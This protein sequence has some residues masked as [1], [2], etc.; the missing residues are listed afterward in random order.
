MVELAQ[1]RR[2]ELLEESELEEAAG[3][4]APAGDMARDF[5]EPAPEL[6]RLQSALGNGAVARAFTP[7]PPPPA[8]AVAP[9]SEV[10]MPTAAEEEKEG[11]AAETDL[12][13]AEAPA[14]RGEVAPERGEP[15]PEEAP[16][17]ELEPAVAAAAN[18]RDGRQR[19]LDP[20]MK[21][22]IAS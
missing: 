14:D 6:L 15:S 22:L 2:Q 19:W 11:V 16:A 8:A 10:L 17:P 4:R 5:G 12:K 3:S 7:A 21:A 9:P 1:R 13:E 18:L 20:A